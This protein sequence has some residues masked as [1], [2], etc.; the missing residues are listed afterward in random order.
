M[1]PLNL[2][3]SYLHKIPSHPTE[4]RKISWCPA[5]E[6]CKTAM[7]RL[8][9]RALEVYKRKR[10]WLYS[11]RYIY[12]AFLCVKKYFKMHHTFHRVMPPYLWGTMSG[13]PWIA[14]PL[15]AQISSAKMVL[16]LHRA[17]LQPPVCCEISQDDWHSITM[18]VLYKNYSIISLKEEHW[19]TCLHI[20]RQV[21]EFFQIILV[22]D[23]LNYGELL[24]HLIFAT[25]KRTPSLPPFH[26]RSTKKWSHRLRATQLRRQEAGTQT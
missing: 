24:L 23:W 21:R 13:P 20:L 12:W 2:S 4:G 10:M 5:E 15:D 22:C 14:K 3:N 11:N 6:G 18:W 8:E 17:S 1:S 9:D 25:V 7:P 26:T 16:G 19:G